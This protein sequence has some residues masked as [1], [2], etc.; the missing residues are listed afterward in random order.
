LEKLLIPR[1]IDKPPMVF[2]WA[3]DELLVMTFMVGVGIVIEQI[4]LMFVIS[5]FLVKR[6][7]RFNAEQ[8]DGYYLHFCY[9]A[10][11]MNQG[12]GKTMPETSRREYIE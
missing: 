4:F 2:F 6:Y 10:G 12:R 8:L 9:W 11:L 1:H 7:R 5:Q 3:M